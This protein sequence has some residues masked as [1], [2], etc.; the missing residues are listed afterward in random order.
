[1]FDRIASVKVRISARGHFVMSVIK[2]M[3]LISMHFLH[4]KVMVQNS[5]V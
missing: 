3:N 2:R 1:M 4:P 5:M